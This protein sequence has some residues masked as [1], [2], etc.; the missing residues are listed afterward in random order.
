MKQMLT[1]SAYKCEIFMAGD[2]DQHCETARMFCDAQGLCVTITRTNYVYTGGEEAGVI[3]GLINYAR[4]P[5]NREE[6]WAKAEAL[7]KLCRVECAQQSFT[8]QDDKRSVFYS[9]REA[10]K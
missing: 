10:G 6:I 3:I 2:Y 8:I 5:S 4:F 1:T 7:A 9:W